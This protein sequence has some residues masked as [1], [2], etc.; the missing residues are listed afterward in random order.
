[1]SAAL[2][3]TTDSAD[4]KA[5]ILAKIRLKAPVKYRELWRSFDQPRAEWFGPALQA[6]I[7]AKKVAYD[8]DRRLVACPEVI[9]GGAGGAN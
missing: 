2:L 3:P 1:V 8:A 5:A 7:D 9:D 4:R 6:L